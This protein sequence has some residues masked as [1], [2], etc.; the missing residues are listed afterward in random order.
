MAVEP[1]RPI[2]TGRLA[3]R[4]MI[5]RSKRSRVLEL[6][7]RLTKIEDIAQSRLQCKVGPP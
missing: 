5:P 6:T 4:M 1:L 3:S 7:T 2:G